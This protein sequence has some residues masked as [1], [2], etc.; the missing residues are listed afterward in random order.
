ML[1]TIIIAV[2]VLV[3]CAAAFLFLQTPKN[4]GDPSK[5]NRAFST[6]EQETLRTT[7]ITPQELSDANGEN[8]HLAW[9]AINGVVYDVTGAKDW[10]APKWHHGV[11]P[12]GDVTE[13][14]LTSG[15]GVEHIAG[16]TVIGT[17]TP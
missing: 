6:S 8:G 9:I 12:G 3:A 10:Q 15:H 16:L 2:V 17:Y 13:A 4:V 14:F 7:Q 5:F 1:K 11:T